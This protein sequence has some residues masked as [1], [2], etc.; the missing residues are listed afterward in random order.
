MNGLRMMS[1]A[2]LMCAL[3]ACVADAGEE[4]DDSSVS[5]TS[6]EL[7]NGD[8][9]VP[10]SIELVADVEGREE[11][12]HTPN[13]L[14]Y[15][16]TRSATSGQTTVTNRS[17][18]TVTVPVM[19]ITVY[20]LNEPNVYRSVVNLKLAPGASRSLSYACNDHRTVRTTHVVASLAGIRSSGTFN[21]YST[22]TGSPYSVRIADTEADLRFS[23]VVVG[24]Q[25]TL[26]G[27]RK[28]SASRG[29]WYV[30][31][32]TNHSDVT[33]T[34]R[35]VQTQAVCN[36]VTKFK[37]LNNVTVAPGQEVTATVSCN[38]EPMGLADSVLYNR[39]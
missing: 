30:T 1:L 22:T 29:N 8:V 20:C 37:T 7:E 18:A 5:E 34:F 12:V 16:A 6:D 24:N 28:E 33:Q 2:G 19:D 9:L 27:H 4:Y 26:A 21:G 25:V 10:S 36:G 15:S 38:K 23:G 32:L 11:V 3:S 31:S 14:V 17:N 13:G 35:R 39:L